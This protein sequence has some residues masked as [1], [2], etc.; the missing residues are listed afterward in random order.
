MPFL[1]CKAAALIREPFD[2]SYY[3]TYVGHLQAIV[4]LAVVSQHALRVRLDLVLGG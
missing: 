4:R 3:Q 1:M 2:H